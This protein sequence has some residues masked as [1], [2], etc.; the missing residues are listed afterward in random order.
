MADGARVQVIDKPTGPSSPAA[1][2]RELRSP[3]PSRDATKRSAPGTGRDRRARQPR[4]ALAERRQG[5]EYELWSDDWQKPRPGSNSRTSALRPRRRGNIALQ[6]HG[7]R[8]AYRNF[9]IREIKG[10]SAPKP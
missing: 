2:R 7:D 5:G 6:D 9:K 4:R 8:V 10:G 1:R 3:P